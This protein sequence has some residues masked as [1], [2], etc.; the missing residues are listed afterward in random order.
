MKKCRNAL[1]ILALVI[2]FT[3]ILR[4]TILS[5]LGNYTRH[6]CPPFSSYKAVFG[7]SSKALLE[8]VGNIVLFIP[9]GIIFSLIFRWNTKRSLLFGFVLSLIIESCQWFF[10]L[11]SF[12]IDDLIHN[13]VG[14]GIGSFLVA[15]TVLG[16]LLKLENQ[17]KN[18][19]AFLVLSII[20]FLFVF[21][22]HVIQWETMKRLA[23]LNDR[24][25]GNRNLLILS[26]EPSYMGKSNVIITYNPDGS[27][28]IEGSS[29]NRSWIQIGTMKLIPGRYVLTGLS[30][31]EENTIALVLDAYDPDE[32]RNRKITQ[33]V[34]TITESEFV[35]EE[36][37]VIR[38]LISIYPGNEYYFIARPSVF[39]EK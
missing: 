31:T 36:E 16:K 9:I 1:I 20:I 19:A 15:R 12:E 7:G 26:P 37:K 23:A 13:M 10:W 33:E 35:I 21:S 14:A 29:E 39:R 27:I 6:F 8:I 28:L 34:G 38:A 24:E 11:G 3:L 25:D 22:Y 18:V 17:K 30:G 5:R 2:S 32:G 4:L